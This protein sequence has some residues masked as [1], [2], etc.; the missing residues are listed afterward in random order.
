MLRL[1]GQVGDLQVHGVPD[2]AG[3]F[4]VA[5]QQVDQQRPEH[6]PLLTIA[7]QGAGVRIDVEYLVR[8]HIVFGDDIV[9]GNLARRQCLPG[10][11]LAGV[12]YQ[13][14]GGNTLR[15]DADQPTLVDVSLD[16]KLGGLGFRCCVLVAGRVALDDGVPGKD[17][18]GQQGDAKGQQQVGRASERG[19]EFVTQDEH[20]LFH[21]DLPYISSRQLRRWP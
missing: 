4:G 15:N 21:C 2:A 11:L 19:D 9:G 5:V 8:L 18:D 16:L 3:Q 13:V 12:G 10:L 14:A 6:H 20:C 1:G 7:G 17:Q